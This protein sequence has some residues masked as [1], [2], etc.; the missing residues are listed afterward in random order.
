MKL[1]T[2]T[3]AILLIV[4]LFGGIF[5]SQQLGWWSTEASGSGSG[6]GGTKTPVTIKTGEYAGTADPADIRG[7]YTFTDVS[8]NFN[9]PIEDLADAFLVLPSEAAV[10]KCKDIETMASEGKYGEL[11]VGTSSVRAFVA[12][13]LGMEIEAANPEDDIP[14]SAIEV[15]LE[16]GNPTEAQKAK[17]EEMLG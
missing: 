11:E 14:P 15:I 12:N 16:R 7:S 9:I 2:G 13:Y 10:I 6:G 3:L 8:K 5:L 17:L 1:K 4:V